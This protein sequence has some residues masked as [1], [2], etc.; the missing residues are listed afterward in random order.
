MVFRFQKLIYIP[1]QIGLHIRLI[2]IYPLPPGIGIQFRIAA[3]VYRL[4]QMAAIIF[5]G[6][7]AFFDIFLCRHKMLLE[8]N[9]INFTQREPFQ[10]HDRYPSRKRLAHS[11]HQM[12]LLR[13]GQIEIAITVRVIQHNLK[14]IKYGRALLNLVNHQGTGIV[15]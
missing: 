15:Q 1:L 10:F 2:E 5:E 9:I 11:L 6:S 13:A 12:E 3:T 7:L 8:R 4:P 14:F